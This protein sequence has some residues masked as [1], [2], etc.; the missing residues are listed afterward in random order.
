MPAAKLRPVGPSTTT[1]PPVMYSQPWSP[2][3]S[4][5]ALG[6]RVAHR[7]ALA[8]QARGRTR[9]PA[10]RAVE[11]GVA[12]DDVLLGAVG[13]AVRRQDGERRR[14]RGP[15]PCSRWRRRAGV[16]VTPG[17]SQ[18]P[19]RCPAE[20]CRSTLD[21]VRRQARRRRA[22][23]RSWLESM[24]PTQRLTLRTVGRRSRPARRARSPGAACSI[25]SQSSASSST[26]R[27]RLDAA[28]RRA[29][30]AARAWCRTCVRSTPRAFQWS[31][32]SSASSRSA[33]ADELVERADA[34]RRP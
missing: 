10:R 7:E 13:D 19:K 17:A 6:A 30:A 28:A 20:P 34:E 22:L 31:I 32:A 12:D 3:P 5:T 25:S 8:G 26:A 21:R 15:C 23:R 14:P 9:L 4:T 2:T 29:R 1:R 16:K 11:H 18:P 27:R 24:P 33:A